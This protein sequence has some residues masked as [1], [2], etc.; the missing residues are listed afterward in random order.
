MLPC[1]RPLSSQKFRGSIHSPSKRYFNVCS[2][3]NNCLKPRVP[4]NLV[5]AEVVPQWSHW[6]TSFSLHHRSKSIQKMLS[7]LLS[8][9]S[10]L[11]ILKVTPNL[12]SCLQQW[13]AQ[14]KKGARKPTTEV[15][16]LAYWRAVSDWFYAVSED[17]ATL[18]FFLNSD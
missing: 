4:H 18:L 2:S 6:T 10:Y 3:Q 13:Q 15:N 16:Q 7:P 1:P 14:R 12:E 8:F 17:I 9:A 5:L 11:Q